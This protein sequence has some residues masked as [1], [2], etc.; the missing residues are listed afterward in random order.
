MSTTMM[1]LRPATI[2]IVPSDLEHIRQ[3][4]YLK[5]CC[6]SAIMTDFYQNFIEIMAMWLATKMSSAEIENVGQGHHL[7]KSYH[8]IIYRF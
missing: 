2:N 4:D 6:I 3:G 7:Q 1:A 5:N 8:A